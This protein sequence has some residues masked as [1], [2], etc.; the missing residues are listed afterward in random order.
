MLNKIKIAY[1]TLKPSYLQRNV[2][3][4]N[5]AA[6][7]CTLINFNQNSLFKG[8]ILRNLNLRV[9]GIV[10]FLFYLQIFY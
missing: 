1:N 8:H 3:K 5:F 2:G 9:L 10:S 4:L 6:P 7:G